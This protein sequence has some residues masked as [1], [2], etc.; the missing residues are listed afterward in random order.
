MK[1]LSGATFPHTRLLRADPILMSG[2]QDVLYDSRATY[3]RFEQLMA[4]CECL[5][6]T[7][8]YAEPWKSRWCGRNESNRE[9]LRCFAAREFLG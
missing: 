7:V 9:T 4:D 2:L 1:V 3:V 6:I 8:D 5:Y